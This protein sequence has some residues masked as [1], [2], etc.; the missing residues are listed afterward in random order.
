MRIEKHQGVEMHRLSPLLTTCIGALLLSASPALQADRVN[1]EFLF[2]KIKANGAVTENDKPRSYLRNHQGRMSYPGKPDQTFIYSKMRQAYNQQSAMSYRVSANGRS[3]QWI[4]VGPTVMEAP[5]NEIGW[6]NTPWSTT[7]GRLS[8]LAISDRCTPVRCRLW[9]GSASGGL[10]RTDRALAEPNA[11]GWRRVGTGLGSSNIGTVSLDPNDA[12][13]STLWVGTGENNSNFTSGAGQGL[14]QST[15]SGN[16]FIKVPTMIVD[17]EV[18]PDPIDFT[19][20]RGIS[21]VAIP[22]GQPG[23]IYVATVTAMMGMTSVRGGQSTITGGPQG[24]PGLYRTT[25]GGK[26]WELLIVAPLNTFTGSGTPE[27]LYELLSGVKDVRLDPLDPSTVYAS[28]LDDGI[29]R[30]SASLEGGDT[31][32]K[33]IFPIQGPGDPQE[34]YAAFDLAVKDGTTRVYVY[35]GNGA[36]AASGAIYRVDD[37]NVPAVNLA[38]AGVIDPAWLKLSSSDINDSQ[39]YVSNN[40][41]HGQCTYDLFLES[42]DGYPDL[43]YMGGNFTKLTFNP[44]LRS[45]DAG[46]TFTAMG[47]DLQTP[48][49]ATHVDV[50]SG[51]VHP[52][53]PEILFVAGDGGLTRTDG[54]YGSGS[55][56]CQDYMNSLGLF[57]P[58]GSPQDL[59]CQAELNQVPGRI[60]HMNQGLATMQ[61]FNI[62]GDPRGPITRMIAGTQDNSTHIYN[63]SRRTKAWQLLFGLGDGTSASGFHNVNPDILFA[64]FQSNFFFVNFR[65]GGQL[66]GTTQDGFGNSVDYQDLAPTVSWLFSGGPILVSGERSNPTDLLSGRQ[67]MTMD[68]VFP[69][70]QFTGFESIWRT[71][72]NGGDQ[73]FLENNCSVWQVFYLGTP[74]WPDCGDWQPLGTRLTHPDFGDREGGTIVAAERSRGD[75]QTLWAG[76]SL[77]RLFVSKNINHADQGQVEFERVDSLASLPRRFISGIAVDDRDPNIAWVT[78]SGFSA[79]EPGAHVYRV[80]YDPGTETASAQ[81]MNFNLPDYPVNHIVRDDLSGDLYIANDYGVLVLPRG[82]Q[83][84][85]K[86]ARGLRPVLVPHLEIHPEHRKLLIGTFGSGAFYLNLN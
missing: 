8:D 20:T 67:F 82:Q 6:D 25:N 56:L 68:P 59:T 77:G 60:I 35:N 12:S 5:A 13:E 55:H 15:D 52:D 4:F 85:Q 22:P 46:E 11:L 30:S 86:P 47:F 18:S 66:P 64:S 41:C 26:T 32:F 7:Q 9:V 34:S 65:N 1:Q 75:E 16:S 2:A 72:N 39:A 70:T 38:S 78:Y 61:L 83:S 10:W 63:R 58:P 73:T 40:L 79:V 81:P 23:T 37:A 24:R 45:D 49:D 84:W 43:V 14:Y 71:T 57:Y 19:V 42:P 69:D 29:Y 51:L 54:T 17:T 44:V 53:D 36:E 50:R 48:T 31:S 21:Q 74:N 3:N 33:E 27:G 76:T 62:A 28:V 80:S